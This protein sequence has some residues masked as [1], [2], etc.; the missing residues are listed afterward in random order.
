[1]R[2]RN[3]SNDRVRESRALGTRKP[4]P[5]DL[6]AERVVLV[7]PSDNQIGTEEKLR[8]HQTGQL[9]RAFSVFVFHP[10][11]DVLLQKRATDKYHSGGLWSNAC[12]GHPRPGA[13]L[14]AEAQRRLHEEMGIECSLEEVFSFQYRSA[15]P[16]GLT[17]N[18]LDHVF[19][20]VSTQDP[21]PEPAE[22]EDWRWASPPQIDQEL[23]DTADTF[24]VWF[25]LAW[26]ALSKH[27]YAARSPT[28]RERETS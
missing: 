27:R 25:P 9:H 3:A 28:K 5:A 11:G 12:C 24:T 13:E 10:S 26:R 15:L 21:I 1:M 4:G 23:A 20:G 14:R 6:T 22:V 19:I 18:E 8:A 16:G 17:E 2:A 7:D